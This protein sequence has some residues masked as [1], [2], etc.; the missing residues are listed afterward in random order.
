M[1]F[2]FLL[3]LFSKFNSL[4]MFLIFQ[5]LKQLRMFFLHIFTEINS[6]QSLLIK[7]N[8]ILNRSVL[9]RQS[10]PDCI[11]NLPISHISVVRKRCMKVVRM[12]RSLPHKHE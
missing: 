10:S 3:G 4:G 11:I 12:R 5:F 1:N 7:R 8:S 9:F 2:R 6:I